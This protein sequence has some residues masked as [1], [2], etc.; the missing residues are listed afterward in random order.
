MNNIETKSI[1]A[2]VLYVNNARIHSDNQID[3]IASSIKEFGFNVPI[4][5]DDDD[6]VIAG[7]GRLMA[8]R[9]LALKDVPTIKLSHLSEA[10]KKAY[11]LA[12]NKIAEGSTWDDDMVDSELALI[13]ELDPDF[14]IELTGFDDLPIDD[15]E[16]DRD[17][18][19]CADVA[20][21]EPPKIVIKKHDVIS[22]GR[23]TL[24]CG[25]SLMQHAVAFDMLFTDPP[26]GL[27]GYAGRSGKFEGFDGD[28]PAES[29][30]LYKSLRVV[31][32]RAKHAFVWCE[33]KTY[34]NLLSALGMPRS[35]IVWNKK[36]FGMGK[37]Y[38]RQH[39][40]CAYWGDYKGTTESDVW[41]V[42]RDSKYDHPT[43]KPV[44]LAI[45][46][47]RTHEPDTVFD[48]FAGSGSTLIACEM[49]G[50]ICHAIEI[51]EKY[52]QLIVDRYISHVNSS[53]VDRLVKITR[54]DGVLSYQQVKDRA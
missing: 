14:D 31:K 9:K 34:P 16:L 29:K 20:N 30:E 6:V 18:A 5:I 15:D 49:E 44:D 17:D 1:D 45:R 12:D 26:Y 54:G 35:L 41:D 7:N 38:R 50:A 28:T 51:S 3:L 39:E 23:H 22:L 13:H 53:D 48:P 10:Q 43:Q 46:A 27:D 40:F 32:A 24:T 21:E 52:C 2:L 47:I 36:R 42:S 33:W 19:F 11:M 8:A 4:L 37:G 25:D